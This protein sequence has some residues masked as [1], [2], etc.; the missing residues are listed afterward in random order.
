MMKRKRKRK[1]RQCPV[2]NVDDDFERSSN[3]RNQASA[4]VD[5]SVVAADEY[6]AKPS[7]T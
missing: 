6:L 4:S 7:L 5:W 3:V 1:M 2:L